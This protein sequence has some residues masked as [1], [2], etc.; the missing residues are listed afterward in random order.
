MCITGR[1]IVKHALMMTLLSSSSSGIMSE[2]NCSTCCLMEAAMAGTNV[3][4]G[5][6]RSS[7]SSSANCSG[8]TMLSAGKEGDHEEIRCKFK[9]TW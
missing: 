4:F 7:Q 8:V 9:F 6:S 1:V 5:R 3:A 2:V